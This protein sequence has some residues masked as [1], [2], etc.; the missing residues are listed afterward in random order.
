MYPG[1][2]VQLLHIQDPTLQPKSNATFLT[3]FPKFFPNAT[4][5]LIIYPSYIE[6]VIASSYVPVSIPASVS[7]G[8]TPT[9]VVDNTLNFYSTL[10]KTMALP[11]NFFAKSFYVK[12]QF[13]AQDL[14]N[15]QKIISKIP[16]TSM[17]MF[18]ISEPG[19]TARTTDSAYVHRN[20]LCDVVAQFDSANIEDVAP[21]KAWLQQYGE[22]SRFLDD[23]ETYQNLPDIQ[24]KDY[25]N[26]YYGSNVRKLIQ[27]KRKFDP[28]GYLNS[29]QSIPI[30]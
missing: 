29:T 23:G 6:L 12:K 24:L 25:L 11:R 2:E 20:N 9:E 10:N 18:I 13:K 14:G 27:I 1:V 19:A 30:Y 8:A 26:R 4:E 28:A 7:S 15:V 16:S 21:G 5:T 22:A 17:F 3:E